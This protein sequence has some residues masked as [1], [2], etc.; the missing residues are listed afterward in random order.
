MTHHTIHDGDA[1]G[2]TTTYDPVLFPEAFTP[3][4]LPS[5]MP[6]REN[7]TL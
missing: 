6:F 7:T 5:T 4:L 3:H 1:V 2:V